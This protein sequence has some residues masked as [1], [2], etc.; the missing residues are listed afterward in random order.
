M[1]TVVNL[2]AAFTKLPMGHLIA[3]IALAAL[4]L[5]AFAIYVLLAIVRNGRE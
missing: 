1:E 5:A 3:L 4:A 2:L